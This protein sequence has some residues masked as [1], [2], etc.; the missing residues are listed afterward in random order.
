M[1]TGTI[2]PLSGLFSYKYFVNTHRMPYIIS[3]DESSQVNEKKNYNCVGTKK[4][5]S[6]NPVESNINFSKG[7]SHVPSDYILLNWK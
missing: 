4:A 6:Q 5:M 7:L 3:W 1:R 2:A